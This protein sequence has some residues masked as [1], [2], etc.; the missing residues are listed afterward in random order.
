MEVISSRLGQQY[1]A[2]FLKSGDNALPVIEATHKQDPISFYTEYKDNV[3]KCLIDH[4]AVLLRNFNISAVS[5]FNRFVHTICSNLMDYIYRSTPRTKLGGKVY[6]AT[7]YPKDLHIPLHNEFSYFH[8]W[9]QKIIFFCVIPPTTGGETPIA[10]SK[11]V[12]QR[13]P[14]HIRALFEQKKVMYVRNYT[15]GIDLSWQVVFQTDQRSDVEKFCQDNKIDFEW[16]NSDL[17]LTT[18][19]VS[20]ASITHHKTNERIWFNQAHLFHISSLPLKARLSLIEELGEANL[21]R[22]A[23]FGD[24]SQIEESILQ[25]IRDA[26]DQEKIIFPWEKRDILI[27]DNVIMAHGRTPYTGER[28]IVTAMGN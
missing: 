15:K 12:Y 14:E 5:E 11:R 20:Q 2:Y 27:L 6:T 23:F 16:G 24:G 19:Q 1:S 25:P 18:R 3:D 7:E 13:I 10:N 9:P 22:N 8:T 21:T 26:Y 17:E 28:K 4:G